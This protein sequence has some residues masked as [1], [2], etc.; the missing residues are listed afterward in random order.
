MRHEQHGSVL[1]HD[2]VHARDQLVALGLVECL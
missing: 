2:F 1:D